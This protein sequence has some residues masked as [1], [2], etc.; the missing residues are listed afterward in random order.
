MLYG[1]VTDSLPETTLTRLDYYLLGG[2]PNGL[3]PRLEKLNKW[4]YDHLTAPLKRLAPKIFGPDTAWVS[5]DATEVRKRRKDSLERFVLSLS[6]QQ[7]VTGL[8]VLIAGYS[9]TGSMSAYHFNIVASLAWFSSATHLATLAVLKT[10]FREHTTVRNWRVII[11]LVML[12]MLA[13]AQVPGWADKDNS[14]PVFCCYRDLGSGDMLTASAVMVFLI[15]TYA[16][17]IARLYSRDIDWNILD[18]FVDG[19]IRAWSNFFFQ[20]RHS[21][22]SYLRTALRNQPPGSPSS[23]SSAATL[24]V[25]REKGRFSR[26]E[27]ELKTNHS[28]IRSY[29]LAIFFMD[30][31]FA[32]SFSVTLAL[33]LVDLTY[34]LVQVFNY[35]AAT[36]HGGIDGNQDEISFGQLVPLL[37]LLLPLFTVGEIHSGKRQ[38]FIF[39]RTFNDARSRES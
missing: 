35:R 15:I 22:R 38:V 25:E 17:G 10:Y 31:E 39:C 6:D 19:V 34:G 29:T 14:V 3:G 18:A 24:R 32:F 13:V 11:M 26:F 33:L 36:P 23:R 9:Q 7:L 37:L 20:G 12:P 16:E 5:L 28:R 4:K 27:L 30:R 1:Y 2:L 8:A 21:E